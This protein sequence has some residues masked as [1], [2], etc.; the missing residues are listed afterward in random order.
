M[1]QNYSTRGAQ[2]CNST[3]THSWELWTVPRDLLI[4][5]H[6]KAIAVCGRKCPQTWRCKY[7]ALRVH[8]EDWRWDRG[9]PTKRLGSGYMCGSHA[10]S[11]TVCTTWAG[12]RAWFLIC[13]T[14]WHPALLSLEPEGC[15]CPWDTENVRRTIAWVSI[16]ADQQVSSMSSPCLRV[17]AGQA[18]G[19]AGRDRPALPTCFP[20]PQAPGP[21]FPPTSSGVTGHPSLACHQGLEF[22]SL[23][24]GL[25]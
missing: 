10:W 6:I 19:A 18:A 22:A 8:P 20:S 7:S 25:P 2:D 5:R 9:S 13:R 14:G 1:P 16:P 3:H 23:A 24:A 15:V 4:S 11:L 21:S 12:G 17:D